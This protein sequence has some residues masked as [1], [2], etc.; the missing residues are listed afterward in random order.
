M[1][2]IRAFR[3]QKYLG[4][5]IPLLRSPSLSSVSSK[6]GNLGNG[7]ASASGPTPR[8]E[9]TDAGAARRGESGPGRRPRGARTDGRTD[10]RAAARGRRRVC[11]PRWLPPTPP[12]LVR[13]FPPRSSRSFSVRSI[14]VP[15]PSSPAAAAAAADL[16]CLLGRRRLLSPRTRTVGC[17]GAHM[18]KKRGAFCLPHCE[19]SRGRTQPFVSALLGSHP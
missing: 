3:F 17:G 19:V 16:T 4:M 8:C 12:P 18:G 2:L 11:P 15:H 6:I 5:E 14:A 9:R 13:S 1:Q 7:G 10:G